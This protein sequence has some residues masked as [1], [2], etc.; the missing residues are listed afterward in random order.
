MCHPPRSKFHPSWSITRHPGPFPTGV[1]A[2]HRR[3]NGRS[4]GS[5]R[6][7]GEDFSPN[8]CIFC[9]WLFTEDARSLAP[10]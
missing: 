2:K 4:F 9:D 7:P 8:L 1:V 3:E 6:K 5:S 10:V